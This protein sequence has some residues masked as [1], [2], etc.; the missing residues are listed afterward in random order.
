MILG[1]IVE[2]DLQG[3]IIRPDAIY[4]GSPGSGGMGLMSLMG[5]SSTAV[6]DG[7]V[8]WPGPTA[9]DI[10]ASASFQQRYNEEG[11][12]GWALSQLD[13]TVVDLPG[14]TV[15]SESSDGIEFGLKESFEPIQNGPNLTLVLNRPYHGLRPWM[16]TIDI[17]GGTL[18]TMPD[19]RR[20]IG[21]PQAVYAC[22]DASGRYYVMMPWDKSYHQANRGD[23]LSDD[24]PWRVQIAP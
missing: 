11:A 19:G 13:G 17:I 21:N 7:Y 1:T 10:L 18:F 5:A 3:R 8:P 2:N 23:I 24:W 6:G 16:P 9:E 12:I 20:A 4:V 22:T 15:I 14:E